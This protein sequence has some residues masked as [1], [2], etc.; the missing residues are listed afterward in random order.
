MRLRHIELFQAI[1]QPASQHDNERAA[2]ILNILARPVLQTCPRYY[3][4]P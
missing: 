1:L 4:D 3:R 2:L